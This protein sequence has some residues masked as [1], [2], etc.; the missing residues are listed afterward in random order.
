MIS[1]A[2]SHTPKRDH[3]KEVLVRHAFIIAL[4]AA[5]AL[6][7]AAPAA[8][9]DS[10]GARTG[11]DNVYGST[12]HNC[13]LCH[14]A[15][16]TFAPVVVPGWQTSAHASDV[17][18]ADPQSVGPG[19]AGCHSGNYDP[20]KAT[21]TPV[22]GPSDTP[23]VYP[24]GTPT[25]D[26]TAAFSEP[27]V[28]C[29]SCHYNYTAM[30]TSVDYSQLANPQICGQCHARYGK[31]V[32]SYTYTPVPTASP[33]SIQPQ[34]PVGYNWLTT[35][36]ASV[37]NIPMPGAP[38]GN[39][40]WPDPITASAKSHGESA[41]QYEETIQGAYTATPRPIPS[42][43]KFPFTHLNALA[44]LQQTDPN[45]KFVTASGCLECHS[46]DYQIIQRWNEERNNQKSLPT[47]NTAKY[48]DTCVT[49]HDPHAP[50]TQQSVF[51]PGRNPQL[52]ASQSTLCTKCHNTEIGT[53]NVAKTNVPLPVLSPGAEIHHPQL[54]MMSGGAAIG[55]PVTPSVHKGDCVQC[56]MVPTGIEH[57]GIPGTGANHL[58][59]VITPE[60]AA[61]H[62]LT[63]SG[64]TGPMPNSACGQCHATS[65]DS[66]ALYLQPVLDSR[67]SLFD[68]QA[69][70]LLAKL[71]K[72]AVGIGY[73]DAENAALDSAELQDKASSNTNVLNFLKAETNYELLVQDKSRGIH[74]WAYAEKIFDAANSQVSQVKP[75]PFTVTIKA[76][77]TS[78]NTGTK[79]TISGKVSSSYQSAGKK[80][81]IQKKS[82]SSWKTILTL[83]VQPGTVTATVPNPD[84]TYSGKWKVT[85]GKCTLRAKFGPYTF[86]GITRPVGY[87]KTVAVTGK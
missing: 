12:I 33:T 45:D 9:A 84:G 40:F 16:S 14:D 20:A 39:T 75:I 51:N 71:D 64:R 87:S 58:F 81:Y 30:H 38:V 48:G 68:Q 19:C 11:Y 86:S 53:P 46:A 35:D 56:H 43:A 37:L 49:C 83:T 22:P 5:L 44:A 50:G 3:M 62:T 28:G 78:V 79:I 29:S 41:V 54:E 77:K 76:S 31:T 72:A 66:L 73:K 59:T 47:L 63:V 34:Y 17:I 13:S 27:F 85:K 25:P 60:Y 52:V 74:N 24:S 32:A 21:G 82:G 57:D 7:I 36:L 69:A 61:T 23:T 1:M 65:T 80:L 8:L 67:Q 4:V 26:S 15:G 10:N 2:D 42:D 6:L 18:N 70:S 55:V